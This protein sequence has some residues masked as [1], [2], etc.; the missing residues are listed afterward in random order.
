MEPE[1][2]VAACHEGEQRGWE[3]LINGATPEVREAIL[4]EPCFRMMYRNGFCD[5]ANFGHE[6]A[7]QAMRKA[8]RS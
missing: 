2:V 6:L 8:F 7:S 3:A 1:Q 5:G 4:G